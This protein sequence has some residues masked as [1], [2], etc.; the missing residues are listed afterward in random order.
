[1][2]RSNNRALYESIMRKVSKEVK[3]SLN[4]FNYWQNRI[5]R[6]KGTGKP[7]KFFDKTNN[8]FDD[9]CS[10]KAVE[11]I[12]EL[13]DNGEIFDG[14]DW[15]EAWDLVENKF[16]ELLNQAVGGDWWRIGKKL[17][18]D[19]EDLDRIYNDVMQAKTD[20]LANYCVNDVIVLSDDE[21]DYD[22]YD[23]YEDDYDEWDD[24]PDID[25]LY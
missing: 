19:D 11:V 24:T 8:F 22:D 1:M 15:D 12:N 6:I 7:E 4:E 13:I 21:D 25:D 23:D 16:Q 10:G 14:M 20:D 2:K 17:G 18:Y 5:W 9:W 3:K